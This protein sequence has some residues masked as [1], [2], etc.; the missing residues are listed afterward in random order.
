MV[1]LLACVY[2]HNTTSYPFLK[3]DEVY[4]AERNFR[5]HI[6]YVSMG[7]MGNLK[8]KKRLFFEHFVHPRGKISNL[9]FKWIF[10][11]TVAKICYIKQ[12]NFQNTQKGPNKN[13]C[14]NLHW[15]VCANL[16]NLKKNDKQT[17]PLNHVF[18]FLFKYG[19]RYINY[20]LQLCTYM[21]T[22]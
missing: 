10:G 6:M 9:V 18:R 1:K 7:L 13:F 15:I 11:C 4:L 17:M 20:T 12:N 8:K 3:W 16:I 21:L 22:H 14:K 19:G 5:V 2:R